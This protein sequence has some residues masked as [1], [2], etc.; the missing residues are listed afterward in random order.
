[1]IASPLTHRCVA[2]LSLAI[3]CSPVAAQTP[4]AVT[5]DTAD[6]CVQLQQRL[7]AEETAARNPPRREVTALAQQGHA[8]CDEGQ[9]RGGILR[10]RRALMMMREDGAEH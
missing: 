1:M 8:L 3:V 9:V 7:T 2:W 6:Y 5:T 4:E 10:L